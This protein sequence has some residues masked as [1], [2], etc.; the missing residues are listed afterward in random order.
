[1]AEDD[2]THL[3][4]TYFSTQSAVTV[5][6]LFVLRK[7]FFNYK[8]YR[9]EELTDTTFLSIAPLKAELE[10]SVMYL[11]Q[12]L[13]QEMEADI[14]TYLF[15]LQVYD[16]VYRLHHTLL[17]KNPDEIVDM[18]PLIDEILTHFHPENQPEYFKHL[19]TLD[20][21]INFLKLL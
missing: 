10:R 20:D 14:K 15:Q 3:S 16:V 1:M 17:N 21:L 4:P 2:L 11:K 7:W 19:G 8:R 18:I 12:S 6:A 9:S 5:S 13:F